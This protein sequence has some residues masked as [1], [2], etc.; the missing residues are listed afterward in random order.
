MGGNERLT[1]LVDGVALCANRYGDE[2]L[3]ARTDC[4]WCAWYQEIVERL[5]AYEDAMPL[6]RAQELARAEADGRL[7][8]LPCKVG[9]NLYMAETL[10]HRVTECEVQGYSHVVHFRYPTGAQN[11][12]THL[13]AIG[14]PKFSGCMTLYLTRE[15]AEAA[16]KEATP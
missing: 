11:L 6:E 15:A 9:E 14:D 2:C 8:L 5:A 13:W 16:A 3:S 4:Q 7:V 10:I 1:E 12:A